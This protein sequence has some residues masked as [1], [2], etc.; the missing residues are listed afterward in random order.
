MKLYHHP[1]CM[2]QTFQKVRATTK[3]IEVNFLVSFK[4]LK[5]FRFHTCEQIAPDSRPDILAGWKL[6]CFSC[7]VQLNIVIQSSW[8]S[9]RPYNRQNQQPVYQ[10]YPQIKQQRCGAV[11]GLFF[12]L[13]YSNFDVL[14]LFLKRLRL[15]TKPEPKG[16]QKAGAGT[17][18]KTDPATLD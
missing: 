14:Q 9:E 5:E 7:P 17:D 2:F 13:C 16:F 8:I 1:A 6:F 11:A 18:Q 3:V 12:C 10:W 4:Q 15:M